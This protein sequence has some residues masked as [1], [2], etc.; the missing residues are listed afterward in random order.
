MFGPTLT[1]LKQVF[2]RICTHVL[3]LYAKLQC[4]TIFEKVKIISKEVLIKT[5]SLEGQKAYP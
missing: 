5:A 3:I 4:L 1:Y 2:I